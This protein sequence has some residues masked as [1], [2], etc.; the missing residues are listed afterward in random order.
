MLAPGSHHLILYKSPETT[1]QKALFNCQ[2]LDL[3]NGEVPLYIAET[4]ALTTMPMPP[5]VAY[6]IPAG[7]MVKLEAHYLNATDQAVQ[8]QGTIELT[9]G[10]DASYQTADIMF[11]GSVA[12]LLTTGVPPGVSALPYDFYQPPAGINIFGLTTHEHKRGTLMTLEKSTGANTQGTLLVNGTPYDNPPF[13]LYPA[14]NLLTFAAHEGI[15]WQC[16]YDNKTTKTYHFGQSAQDD[17]M[18]FF[19]GYYYPSAGRFLSQ[20]DCWQ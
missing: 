1:E 13:Q 11:C 8:G 6:K 17:E 2:A 4:E 5:G 15:R 9:T 16:H 14:N 18:C 20:N 7:Q 10:N 19:W 3:S 12:P